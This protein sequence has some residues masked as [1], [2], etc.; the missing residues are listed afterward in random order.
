MEPVVF[1]N[2]L[3]LLSWTSGL[4]YRGEQ[5]Y[6]FRPTAQKTGENWSL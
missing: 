6:P 2:A 1:A 5:Q 4:W 3:E